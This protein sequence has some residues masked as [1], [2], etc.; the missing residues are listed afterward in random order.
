[1]SPTNGVVNTVASVVA[2]PQSLEVTADV[3]YTRGTGFL[4]ADRAAGTYLRGFVVV[5]VDVV[6]R[7]PGP[8]GQSRATDLHVQG[9][10]QPKS[11]AA[12]SSGSRRLR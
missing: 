4:Q 2:T 12:S 1:M 6:D 7:T 8:V 9:S 5:A 3:N 10:H 11:K